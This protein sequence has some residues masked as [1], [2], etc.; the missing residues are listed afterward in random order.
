MSDESTN[1]KPAA[2]TVGQPGQ[3]VGQPARTVNGTPVETWGDVE[4]SGETW[5]DRGRRTWDGK[6]AGASAE[7][8]D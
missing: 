3:T 6:P 5:D 1:E 8:E 2:G 4:A 7:R